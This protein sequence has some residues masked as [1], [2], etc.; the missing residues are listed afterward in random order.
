MRVADMI[1]TGLTSVVS[2]VGLL[3]LIIKGQN[4]KIETLENNSMQRERCE[5]L[6][7]NDILRMSDLITKEMTQLK[8]EVF[9]ELREINQNVNE[10]RSEIKK[11]G[12]NG[13]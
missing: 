2:S 3:G 10:I 13:R 1:M 6:R 7:E 8:D 12:M 4:K 11:G 9:T 5:L